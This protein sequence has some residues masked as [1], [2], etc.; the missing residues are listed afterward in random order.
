[1]T[2][3]FIILTAF[4]T[5]KCIHKIQRFENVFYHSALRTMWMANYDKYSHCFE[6]VIIDISTKIIDKIFFLPVLLCIV[7]LCNLT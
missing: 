2:S 7:V 4:D 6:M 5:S 1:M 3:T